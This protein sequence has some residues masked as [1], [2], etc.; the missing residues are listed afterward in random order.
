MKKTILSFVFST[1]LLGLLFSCFCKNVPPYWN[2]K[3]LDILFEDNDYN[4]IQPGL[5]SMDT[6][7]LKLYISANYISNNIT[8]SSFL[9]SCYATSC[10]D[11]GYLGMKDELADIIVTSDTTYNNIPKGESLAPFIK[12]NNQNIKGWIAEKGY[13]RI[14]YGGSSAFHLP[15]SLI[16]RP[17]SHS[18]HTFTVQLVSRSG[19]TISAVSNSLTWN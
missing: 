19:Q 16:E 17:T 1:S 2:P 12:I 18:T 8:P 7:V 10:P 6:V 11:Y 3:S 9:N 13:N 5:H 4:P 15:I 14:S